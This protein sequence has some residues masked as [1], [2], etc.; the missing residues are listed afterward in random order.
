MSLIE[1]H[2]AP[3]IMVQCKNVSYC[4]HDVMEHHVIYDHDK[5]CWNVVNSMGLLCTSVH[6]QNALGIMWQCSR[7]DS[8]NWT[9]LGD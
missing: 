6:L 7:I 9:I 8:S 1:K 4:A 3:P 2:N 5:G